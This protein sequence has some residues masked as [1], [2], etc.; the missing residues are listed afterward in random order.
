MRRGDSVW[1]TKMFALT[2]SVSGPLVPM[3]RCMI[4]AIKDTAL[5]VIPKWYKTDIQA[6]KKIIEGK[7]L[8]AKLSKI[9]LSPNKKFAPSFEKLISL[10]I[11]LSKKP[12]KGLP[13]GVFSIK[14]AKINCKPKPHPTVL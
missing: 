4:F 8:N 9:G 11:A 7:T 5:C 2:L 12:K 14:K 1:P 13:I 3:V 6:E 10:V